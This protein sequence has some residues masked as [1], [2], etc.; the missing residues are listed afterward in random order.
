MSSDLRPKLCVLEKGD[1]GYGFHLHGEKNKSGQYIRHVEADSPAAEAGLMA[2]DKLAFVNGENVED[3]KHQQVVSLI[4]GITGKL[5]LVVLDPETANLLQKHNLKCKKEYVIDGIPIPSNAESDHEEES[6]NGTPRESTPVPETNGDIRMDR[7]SVS[8]KESKNELRPRLCHM[9]KGATGYGF[10]LHT[11]K[12]KPGQF[13]R[14]VDED[15]P[16]EKSGLRPQDKIVEVN[17]IPVYT[18][19][20]SEVVAAIKTGGDETR[21]LVVDPETDAFFR[22]CDVLPTESHLTGPLPEPVSSH[23]SEDQVNGKAAQQEKP[24]VA[25]SL[26][27]SSTSSNTSTSAAPASTSAPEEK[28]KAKASSDDAALSLNISLQQAKER[29]HQK[30]SNKRAPQMEW[31]KRNE[32]FSNL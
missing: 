31:S 30:R 28:P 7:L 24:K 14:A 15:S 1:N 16:A 17:G 12:T 22:S 23:D 21:L 3:E 18:M 19:Q 27:T 11:E 25:M 32:L 8:S 6:K 2:G 29:A 4:R 13:I 26:S 10:N 20:H 9:K 5:E